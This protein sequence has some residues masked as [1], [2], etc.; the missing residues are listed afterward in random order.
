MS[1][2]LRSLITNGVGNAIAMLAMLPAVVTGCGDGTPGSQGPRASKSQPTIDLPSTP[3]GLV[4]PT[5][6][7][8]TGRSI[9]LVYEGSSS[10]TPTAVVVDKHGGVGV[11]WENEDYVS[12]TD[13][14][15]WCV[16]A[17]L[18]AL[19]TRGVRRAVQQI[20]VPTRADL[21]W[22][23]VDVRLET[24]KTVHSGTR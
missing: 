7:S 5:A 8:I 24:R 2:R 14:R 9:R 13:I 15:P 10:E 21:R 1:R 23:C 17:E 11:L 18:E 20:R 19:P 4:T 16:D 3:G 22:G 6:G 12:T